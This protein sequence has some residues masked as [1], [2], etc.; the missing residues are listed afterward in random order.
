MAEFSARLFLLRWSN[1]VIP[2]LQGEDNAGYQREV[3][4]ADKSPS[5]KEA[6][7]NNRPAPERA[8]V[9]PTRR[10]VKGDDQGRLLDQGSSRYDEHDGK[11]G[12]YCLYFIYFY[13]N[14]Y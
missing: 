11:G 1:N 2:F 4:T 14:H 12:N 10:Q 8:E 13:L 6:S 3:T 5:P 7:G 9:M